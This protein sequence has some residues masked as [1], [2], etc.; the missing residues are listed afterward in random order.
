MASSSQEKWNSETESWHRAAES[1]PP[2]GGFEETSGEVPLDAQQL[3]AQELQPAPKRNLRPFVLLFVAVVVF[4]LIYFGVTALT[5]AKGPPPFQNLGAGISNAAGLRGDLSTRWVGRAEYQLKFQALNPYRDWAFS[6]VVAHPPRPL[7]FH[8][9]LLDSTGFVLC[10]KEIAFPVDPSRVEV[11]AVPFPEL[12]PKPSGSSTA[13]Q[14]G[15]GMQRPLSKGRDSFQD[16]VADNGEITAFAAQGV[17]PCTIAQ[18]KQFSYW[19]FSS[20]FPTLSQQSAIANAPRIAA[21]RK[22]AAEREA[23]RRKLAREYHSSFFLNG[24]STVSDYDSTASVLQVASGQ[25]FRLLNKSNAGVAHSWATNG[26]Q[27]HYKC[28]QYAT[29]LLSAG[30]SSG[31]IQAKSI[32]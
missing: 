18:Y 16:Q 8:I 10:S 27:I 12:I 15:G 22:A 21:E 1:A 2:F 6:Y 26:A 31:I 19:D 7:L 9:R 5:S 24:D 28:D 14:A 29:C 4:G 11:N 13:A 17:L 20:N 25:R 30:S 23:L 32:P 3:L